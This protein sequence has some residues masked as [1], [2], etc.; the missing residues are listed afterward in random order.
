V[1]LV[2]VLLLLRLAYR[3]GS[4]IFLV[5]FLAV[6]IRTAIRVLRCCRGW[7]QLVSLDIN[8]FPLS[9][10]IISEELSQEP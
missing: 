6:C 10:K 9:K 7:V 5:S 8:I 3:S 4:F 1:V 2:V